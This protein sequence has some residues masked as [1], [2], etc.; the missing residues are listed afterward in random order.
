MTTE[1]T[2]ML[3]FLNGWMQNMH[4]VKIDNNRTQF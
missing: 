2:N 1:K 4:Q 3:T